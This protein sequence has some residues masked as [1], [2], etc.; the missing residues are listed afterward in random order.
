MEFLVV[1]SC[2]SLLLGP[3]VGRRLASC[4]ATVADQTTT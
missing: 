4:S 2:I 1:W 3:L